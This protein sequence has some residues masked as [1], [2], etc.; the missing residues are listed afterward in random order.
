MPDIVKVTLPDGS[1]K[2][3]PTMQPAFSGETAAELL[4]CN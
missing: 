3:V 4:R 1:S 2:E